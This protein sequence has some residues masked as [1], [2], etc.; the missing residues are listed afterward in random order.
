MSLL[1]NR[2][3][4]FKIVLLFLLTGVA[5]VFV[6]RLS[7]G[8]TF[9]KHFAETL[10]PHLQQYVT[11][12]SKEIGTPPNLK[13][14]QALSESLKIRII[15]KGPE[16]HW[17]S[18]GKFLEESQI[19]FKQSDDSQF[20]GG[21]Y[22]NHDF[23]FRITQQAYT[24]TIITQKNNNL[25][26]AGT[27]LLKGLLGMLL[28]LGLLYFFLRHMISPLKNIQKSVKRIGSGE[29]DH[30]ISIQAND[31]CGDLSKEINS[32]AD[33][34]KNMLEAKR[35]LLLAI[36]HELRS[37]I[38]RAKVATSLM[39]DGNIREEIESDLNEMEAMV[40]GLLEAE[41]LNHRHQTLNLNDT[42]INLL[43]SDIIKQY[44][45]EEPILQT[46]DS[47]IPTLNLDEARFQFV[48]KNLLDNALKHR[49]KDSDEISIR[50]ELSSLFWILEIED[51]G[52]GIPSKHLPHLSEPFY[53]VDPSRHRK[54][55]GYG[56]GLYIIKMIVEAHNGELIIESKEALGTKVCIKL[57]LS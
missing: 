47:T 7:S 44:F 8:G 57:P 31:E 54:T 3:L 20:R 1:K 38:T 34:I 43:I 16:L 42:N 35:Q 15:I 53:R 49:K 45:D 14:A 25:P 24:T 13:T 9:I 51:Q 29:L 48:V 50:T 37:P 56:L 46:L 17:S 26:S 41:Q 2:S 36:S 33:D 12:I 11:Y 32:M 10:R 6:L 52:I 4:S 55:G 18:N 23:V 22:N 27:L 40:S 21:R 5:L 30:R 19:I 39:D 28:V